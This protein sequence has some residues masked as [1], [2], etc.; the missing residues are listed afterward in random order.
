VATDGRDAIERVGGWAMVRGV[1]LTAALVAAPIASSLAPVLGRWW[2]AAERPL[3][4][5]GLAGLVWL[6]LAVWVL[7]GVHALLRRQALYGLPA[8]PPSRAAAGAPALAARHASPIRV[9]APRT[10]APAGAGG[11]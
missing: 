3:A 11:R 6:L 1:L 4:V 2:P 9:A 10:E 5:A 8:S 7:H